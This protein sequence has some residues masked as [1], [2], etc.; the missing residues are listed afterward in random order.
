MRGQRLCFS[1]RRMGGRNW[2]IGKL[3]NWEIGKLGNWEIGKL[4]NWEIGKLGNWEIGKLGNWEIGKLGNWEIRVLFSKIFLLKITSY[5][6]DNNGNTDDT[7][8]ADLHG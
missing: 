5:I 6:F 3:G 7:D 4:G 8:W 2:E 1:C